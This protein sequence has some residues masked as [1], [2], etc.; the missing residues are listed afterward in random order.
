[1]QAGRGG[2][3]LLGSN[4]LGLALHAVVPGGREGLVPWKALA[5]D[6]V[7]GRAVPGW[8]SGAAMPPCLGADVGGCRGRQV[9]FTRHRHTPR[10]RMSENGRT[11]PAPRGKGRPR[12][13]AFATPADLGTFRDATVPRS[14]SATNDSC[15]HRH[16][17]TRRF[18]E[19]GSCRWRHRGRFRDEPP[20]GHSG[21]F[22]DATSDWCRDAVVGTLETPVAAGAT[23]P[24]AASNSTRTRGRLRG[25]ET[26]ELADFPHLSPLRPDAAPADRGIAA[27]DAVER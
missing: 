4:V 12:H 17:G 25:L 26:Y 11:R 14:A 3:G 8:A 9:V 16:V 24:M 19:S 20:V 13:R 21:T 2:L 6:G 27:R 15:R 5:V 10:F 7:A 1:M 22:R 18:A 23:P